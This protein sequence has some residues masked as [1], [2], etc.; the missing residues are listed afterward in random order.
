VFPF[1]KFI[2]DDLRLARYLSDPEV[3]KIHNM[4]VSKRHTKKNI[5]MLKILKSFIRFILRSADEFCRIS[6]KMYNY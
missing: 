4:A 5:S 3:A 2:I 6:L 1:E